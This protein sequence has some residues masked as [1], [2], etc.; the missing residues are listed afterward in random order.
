M[1]K[2]LRVLAACTS[3]LGSVTAGANDLGF[4]RVGDAVTLDASTPVF[5][6]TTFEILPGASVQ[7]S[8]LEAGDTLTL[9]ASEAIRIWGAM[10]LALASGLRLEAPMIEIGSDVTLEMAGGTISIVADGAGSDTTIA[11]TGAFILVPGGDLSLP[12]APRGITGN[13]GL[14]LIEPG[15]SITLQAPV[16][17]AKTWAML[18]TGLGLVGFVAARRKLGE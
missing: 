10:N 7:F 18:T 5:Y 2:I 12:D 9:H 17:E 13:N 11:T 3:L 6:F 15:G 8:G 16:P 4:M 1:L 14:Q